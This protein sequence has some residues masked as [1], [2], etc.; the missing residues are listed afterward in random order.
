[1]NNIEKLESDL[2]EAADHLR[3]N[4]KL[5]SS[6]Y[7]MPVLGLIFLRHATNRY[8]EALRQIRADQ[9]AGAIAKRPI[10]KG[11]FLKRRALQ[12]P[13]E[14]QYGELLKRPTRSVLS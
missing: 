8:D 6:E 12:L 3:S 7:C 10:V 5:T 1:M 14:A 11:D 9:A 13:L 2:W 4:S